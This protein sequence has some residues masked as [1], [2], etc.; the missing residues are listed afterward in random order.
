MIS[1]GYV[2]KQICLYKRTIYVRVKRIYH[3]LRNLYQYW[4]DN[5]KKTT[6]IETVC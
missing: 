5:L 1:K 2:N 6:T 3:H 4:F